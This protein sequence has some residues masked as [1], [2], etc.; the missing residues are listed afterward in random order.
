MP[1][2]IFL[3]NKYQQEVAKHGNKAKSLQRVIMK[4]GNATLMTNLTTASGFATFILTDSKVLKEFGII[5]SINII[6]IF[7][8]SLLIIPVVYSFMSRPSKKHLKH[9]K[10]HY[11]KTFVKW[12]ENK[13]RFKRI[14]VYFISLIGLIMG[15]IGIYQINISGSIIEDMPKKSEFFSD[16]LFFDEEFNGIA[17]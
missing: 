15:I 10:S 12:M 7:L 13:V 1:N 4:I 14:N 9:L 17:P 6:A 5:A 16:I 11:L 8:L 2:C 3:I